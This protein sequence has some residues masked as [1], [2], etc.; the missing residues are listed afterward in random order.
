VRFGDQIGDAMKERGIIADLI[1]S[2]RVARWAYE[3]TESA[4][5]LT[6]LRADELEPLNP[7]WRALFN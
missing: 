3:Q 1:V 4:N 2:N 6:W 5:G 7:G